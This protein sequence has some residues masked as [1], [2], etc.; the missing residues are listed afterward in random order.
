LAA[1]LGKGGATANALNETRQEFE[2]TESEM[3]L[4]D[5]ETPHKNG[6]TTAKSVAFGNDHSGLVT[7][8]MGGVELIE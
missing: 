7:H 2:M 5:A 4:R 8:T 1:G 3:K 6:R